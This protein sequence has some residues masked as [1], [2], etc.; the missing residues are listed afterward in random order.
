MVY[1]TCSVLPEENDEAIG[2]L[3]GRADRF[4]PVPAADVLGR[5]GLSRLGPAVRPTRHGLQMTPLKTGTDG[6][7]VAMLERRR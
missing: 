4:A 1:V 5:A 3:L 2:E 7:F 6:F